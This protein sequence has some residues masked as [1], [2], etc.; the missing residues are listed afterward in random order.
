MSHLLWANED[1]GDEEQGEE[2]HFVELLASD[3]LEEKAVLVAAAEEGSDPCLLSQAHQEHVQRQVQQ[4]LQQALVNKGLQDFDLESAADADPAALRKARF[5]KRKVLEAEAAAK[6]VQPVAAPF[7]AMEAELELEGDGINVDFLQGYLGPPEEGPLNM[8]AGS[9]AF[10]NAKVPPRHGTL[11][12]SM[13]FGTMAGAK[14][15]G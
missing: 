10:P 8:R 2:D 4:V 1:S 7:D 13:A 3:A 5:A 11:G 6:L 12:A 14:E 15:L 9:S